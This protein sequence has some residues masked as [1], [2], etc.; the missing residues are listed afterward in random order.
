MRSI[1]ALLLSS[2]THKYEPLAWLETSR[3]PRQTVTR[4]ILSAVH[5]DMRQRNYI[6]RVGS[7]DFA[8]DV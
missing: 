3:V 8:T 5:L 2:S 6:T 1:I 7:Q 4:T